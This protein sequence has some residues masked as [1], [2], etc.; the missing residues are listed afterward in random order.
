MHKKNW[1]LG[2]SLI[3]HSEEV[4]KFEFLYLLVAKKN[5]ANI[6]HLFQSGSMI[7]FIQI[8]LFQSSDEN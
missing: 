7:Q 3:V 6:Q 8:T 1:Y 4:T 5:Y 2:D